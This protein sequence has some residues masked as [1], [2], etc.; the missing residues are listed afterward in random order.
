MLKQVTSANSS[1][2]SDFSVCYFLL[3]VYMCKLLHR[4]LNELLFQGAICLLN[5]PK[6]SSSPKSW[7]L[8]I[9]QIQKMIVKKNALYNNGHHGMFLLLLFLVP[10]ADLLAPVALPFCLF[11]NWRSHGAAKCKKTA[12]C[13]HIIFQSQWEF[14]NLKLSQGCTC[15]QYLK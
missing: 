13:G 2:C 4:A 6:W 9:F 8:F 5:L 7:S 11:M 12:T 14:W 1:E 10:K 3:C 15:S